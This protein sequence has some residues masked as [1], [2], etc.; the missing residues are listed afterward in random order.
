MNEMTTT[1]PDEAA[2]KPETGT[3]RLRQSSQA[4]RPRFRPEVSSVTGRQAR[5]RRQRPLDQLK[6]ILLL[7]LLFLIGLGAGA[8]IGYLA[9]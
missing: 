4:E 1:V 5:S 6:L 9:W 2:R 7:A 3:P 8:G